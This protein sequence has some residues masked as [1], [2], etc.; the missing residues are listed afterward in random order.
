MLLRLRL[1]LRFRALSSSR[2]DG[3]LK[4]E[5]EGEVMSD[6]VELCPLQ[7]TDNMS[8]RVAALFHTFG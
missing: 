7:T 6:A 2:F 1:Q 3:Q 5:R 8:V 4:V